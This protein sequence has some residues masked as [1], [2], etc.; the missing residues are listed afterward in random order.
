[1]Q[2]EEAAGSKPPIWAAGGRT[3]LFRMTTSP[4]THLRVALLAL[5]AA[6][7]AAAVCAFAFHPSS[8]AGFHSPPG[9]SGPVG[10]VLG[11]PA[12]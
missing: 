2:T 3:D 10:A 5:V 8:A 1:M 12:S 11:A 9:I 6:G 4:F 7:L